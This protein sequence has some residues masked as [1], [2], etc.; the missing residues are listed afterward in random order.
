MQSLSAKKILVVDDQPSMRRFV[1]TSLRQ[2]GAA[3]FLFGEN[4]SEA[5]ETALREHPD[6]IVMDMSMPQGSGLSLLRQLKES[7]ETS[8]IPV[9]IISGG[10]FRQM[11]SEGDAI[12]VLRKPFTCRQILGEVERLFADPGLASATQKG[13]YL[14]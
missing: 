6:L 12:A 1:E 11:S 10:D 2:A 3:D 14:A 9:V 7:P 4:G 5:V 13:A 8:G